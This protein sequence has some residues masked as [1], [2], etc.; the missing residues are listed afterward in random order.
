M[1]TYLAVLAQSTAER[2]PGGLASIVVGIVIITSD[3]HPP[4]PHRP[5]HDGAT[6]PRLHGW[7]RQPGTDLALRCHG[8]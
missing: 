8:D 2:A 1:V 3:H 7:Y 4:F 5:C 6:A